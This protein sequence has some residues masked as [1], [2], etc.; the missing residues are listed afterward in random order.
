MFWLDYAMIKPSKTNCTISPS[1][2]GR[3]STPSWKRRDMRGMSA[4]VPRSSV[5]RRPLK[6]MTYELEDV[7]DE[8]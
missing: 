5:L 6:E 3:N 7:R 2:S 1:T 4:G 8:T